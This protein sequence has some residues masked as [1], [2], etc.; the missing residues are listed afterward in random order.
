MTTAAIGFGHHA[1]PNLATGWITP[2]MADEPTGSAISQSDRADK[3]TWTRYIRLMPITSAANA[4][5]CGTRTRSPRMTIASMTAKTGVR[6]LSAP[7]MFGPI[8]RLDSKFSSAAAPGK[9]NPTHANQATAL[10]SPPLGWRRNGAR[11][12]KSSVEVGT[13][14]ATPTQ[15]GIQR[16]PNWVRTKP[17]PNP[18]IDTRARTIAVVMV[19]VSCDGLD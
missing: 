13:L 14:I 16:N 2:R 5:S 18:N 6:L 3:M 10:G 11:H 7:A 1:K 4:S 9:T 12:Q 17:A 19:I 8:R 15:G